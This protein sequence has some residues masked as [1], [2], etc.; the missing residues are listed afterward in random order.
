MPIQLVIV[1]AYKLRDPELIMG[2]KPIPGA[3][4]WIQSDT[5]DIQ[6]KVSPSDF[7]AMQKL[8]ED[9]RVDRIKRMMQSM[10]ADRFHLKVNNQVES[11]RCYSLVIDKSGPKLK[12]SSKTPVSPDGE[13][14]A[15]PGDVKG[16]A[17]PISALV[18]ALTAPLGCRPQDKTGLAGRYDVTLQYAVDPNLGAYR[19][20]G[21]DVPDAPKISYDTSAPSLFTAIRTQ[22]GLKLVPANILK[23][24]IL[25]EHIERPSAN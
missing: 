5:Y 3:P 7:A 17:I 10:L 13:M 15:S 14:V 24:S 9:Q 16:E 23:E 21:A 1:N 11:E 6:A 18:F 25:I 4:R 12:V 20:S 19:R 2:E 8:T 22:L